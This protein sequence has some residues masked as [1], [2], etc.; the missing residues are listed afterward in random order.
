[1]TKEKKMRLHRVFNIILAIFIILS[2]LC[3]MAGCLRIYFNVA[4]EG[5]LPVFYPDQEYSRALVADTFSYIAI[6]VYV[7]VALA[8]V[9]M[10]YE[11]IS[12]LPIK[13]QKLNITKQKM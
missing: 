1:M 9:G 10:V 2:G 4:F 5:G 12:P 7:T 6:P 13:K 8:A 11:F 3:F